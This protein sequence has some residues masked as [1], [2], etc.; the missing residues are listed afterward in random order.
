MKFAEKFHKK[1]KKESS[2]TD[3]KEIKPKINNK[4]SLPA[5]FSKEQ[6]VSETTSEDIEELDK[7][8]TELI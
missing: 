6:D 3:K 8:L 2:T 1:M 7:L 4:Q 5:W